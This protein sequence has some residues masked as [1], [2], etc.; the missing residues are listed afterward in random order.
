MAQA[1]R[2]SDALAAAT[3][4]AADALGRPDLGRIEEGALADVLVIDGDPLAHARA[5]ERVSRVHESGVLLDRDALALPRGTSLSR[6]PRTGAGRGDTCLG[7]PE[8]GE[9][10]SCSPDQRCAATCDRTSACAPGSACVFDGGSPTGG[11]CVDGDGC[12]P[13]ASASTARRSRGSPCG[14]LRVGRSGRGARRPSPRRAHR[15]GARR[16]F[17]CRAALTASRA[18]RRSRSPA[19]RTGAPRR[20]ARRARSAA[21]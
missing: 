10:L 4:A 21:R 3:R 1:A 7:A 11:S 6:Q 2:R 12:D 14:R 15:D 18:S 20:R 19:R 9:A 5:L 16:S 13:F 8:C 17:F